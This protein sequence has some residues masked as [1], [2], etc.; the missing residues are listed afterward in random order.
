MGYFRDELVAWVQTPQWFCD[1]TEG[2]VGRDIFANKIFFS[3]LLYL[4]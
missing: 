1:L 3:F 2:K 4:L